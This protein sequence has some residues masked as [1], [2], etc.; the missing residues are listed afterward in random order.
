MSREILTCIIH[1]FWQKLL[2]MHN[3]NKLQ[4]IT[5]KIIFFIIIFKDELFYF[6]I[7]INDF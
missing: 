4:D 6:L 1:K 7:Y 3:N 2:N 5:I